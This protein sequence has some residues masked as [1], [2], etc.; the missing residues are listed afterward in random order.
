MDVDEVVQDVK[1]ASCAAYFRYGNSARQFDKFNHYARD[2]IA[3]SVAKHYRRN[4]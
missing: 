3:R 4:Q 1:T 2:R